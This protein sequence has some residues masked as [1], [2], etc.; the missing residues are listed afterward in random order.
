LSRTG[1]VPFAQSSRMPEFAKRL[2]C[3][4]ATLG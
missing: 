4:F 3:G 1:Q 2:H